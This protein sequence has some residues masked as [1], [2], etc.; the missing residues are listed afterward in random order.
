MMMLKLNSLKKSVRLSNKIFLQMILL[1]LYPVGEVGQEKV[2]IYFFYH[3]LL[4][5]GIIEKPRAPN[6]RKQ[7]ALEKKR[8][9][10]LE[11]RT[12]AKLS[13]VIIS[14]NIDKKATKYQ[15]VCWD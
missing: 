12:D 5:T 2:L 14:Q 6:L 3:F 8:K 15:L 9:E 1:Q 11:K 10:A 7:A 13:N 4:K